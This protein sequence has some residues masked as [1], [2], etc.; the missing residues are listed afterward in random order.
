M[1]EIM[2]LQLN[3]ILLLCVLVM[4]SFEVGGGAQCQGCYNIRSDNSCATRP[5]MCEIGHG[6]RRRCFIRKTLRRGMIMRVT[7]GCAYYCRTGAVYN[8]GSYVVT[9]CCSSDNC[10]S[11]NAW[12]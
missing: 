1:E 7:R 8:R 2:S 9:W 11:M 12:Y 6:G 3:N 5:Y 4:L 10:N